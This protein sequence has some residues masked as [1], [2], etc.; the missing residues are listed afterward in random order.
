MPTIA[1][2]AELT[3]SF[4]DKKKGQLDGAGLDDALKALQKKHEGVDWPK[5]AEGWTKAA[6]KDA[7]KLKAL[8]ETLDKLYRVKASPLKLEATSLATAAD[9]AAKAKDAAKPR[10]DACAL[11]IKE[12]TAYAKA[13]GAGL[14]ALEREFNTALKALPQEEEADEGEGEDEPA[15]ALLDPGR[16]L[17]QLKLCKADPARQVFFAYLDNAKDDPLLA[18]HP[19]TKGRMMMAKISKDVGIKTGSFGLL[20]IDGVQLKLVVEKKYGGLVKRIRIPIKKCGFRIGKVLLVDEKG[21]TLDQDDEDGADTPNTAQ[22]GTQPSTPAG[23]I[24]PG[25]LPFLQ[26]WAKVR[27]DAVTTLKG[28]AKEIA[29]LKDPESAKAVIE[30]SAVVKNLTVEPT[31]PQ[32]I[33]EL[34]RYLDKDDVVLDVSEFASDIRT[35]LLKVLAQLHKA[36]S[37]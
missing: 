27:G 9:K 29:E 31:S 25:A 4:W 35:P 37:A 15:N 19:K 11:I 7:A 12:A 30:I 10:K 24:K 22:T 26:A 34:V 6:G 17:R 2:P 18:A 21:E 8:Y 13:V 36:V 3:K 33:A 28:V 1:L 14:E 16:L 20:S 5:L 23:T 32:Q